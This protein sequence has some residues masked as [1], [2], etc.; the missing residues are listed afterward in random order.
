MRIPPGSCRRLAPFLLMFCS[1]L[2]LACDTLPAGQTFWI[3]LTTPVSSYS[4]KAGDRVD[5]VLIED[6][7]CGDSVVL[8]LGAKISG[9]VRSVRKVG[10]GIRHETAAL[11]L[12]FYR[13]IPPNGQP[14]AVSATVLEV[15]NAREQVTKGVIQGIRSS[16]TPQGR[17]NS[18]LGHLPTWNPYS[19]MGLIVYKA[20]F[21]IFPEPEIYFPAGADLHIKLMEPLQA[22][23][24]P[25][26]PHSQAEDLGS[27]LELD[28]LAAQ[29]PQRS[30]TEKLVE[31]DVVNLAFVGTRGQV[32]SAFEQAGWSTSDVFSKRSFF[33]DFYAFLNNSGYAQAPMRTLLLDGR[34]PD[35]NWQNSLNSYARRD[36]LR[37]WQWSGGT[38]SETVW[39]SSSTH[40]TRATL[41]LEHRQFV[42]HI[43][44]DIDDERSKVIR[45]LNLAGC[46]RSV[47]LVPRPKLAN[48]SQ[49]ATGDL[50]TTDGDLAV[51][52]LKGCDPRV[53][54]LTSGNASP[55]FK[56]S[57][58]VFRY[59]RRQILTFRSDIW[60]AN[61]IYGAY[62]LVHMG[63]TAL[64]HH[65]AGNVSRE[66]SVA[67]AGSN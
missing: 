53:P 4:S 37:I 21:P 55:Q 36:H 6:A 25:G 10:W 22:A 58:H 29:A 60:R 38:D 27:T 56:P 46:V 41:S 51:V 49:N 52:E 44:P 18:R 12:E 8:P 23:S 59:L 65:S 62:D 33:R 28:R 57:N 2:A 31:A 24:A 3:R 5:A 32:E 9:T 34:P 11:H 43:S 40:D 42:H 63:V 35:M 50:V 13:A 7:V 20:T 66:A 39:L 47:H 30:T 45:D 1:V 15:E 19:D 14:M 48:V 16:D 61:I 54:G 67:L 64:R 26:S 17:I